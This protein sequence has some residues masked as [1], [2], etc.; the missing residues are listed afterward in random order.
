[1]MLMASRAA[2]DIRGVAFYQI[3][4]GGACKQCLFFW[5]GVKR[6]RSNGDK[7]QRSDA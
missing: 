2:V 5:T 3:A 6:Q 1:M 7:A 4:I